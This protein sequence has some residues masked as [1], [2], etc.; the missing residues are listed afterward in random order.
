[1]S[2]V[3][4]DRSARTTSAWSGPTWAADLLIH[5]L[6]VHVAARQH[7]H[8]VGHA[9]AALTPTLSLLES[10]ATVSQPPPDRVQS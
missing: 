2:T 6:A 3:T 10:T 4:A 5:D 8:H 7:P 1:M 9:V